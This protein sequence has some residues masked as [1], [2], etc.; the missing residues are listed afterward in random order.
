MEELPAECGR[1]RADG[2]RVSFGEKGIIVYS[3]IS[4]LTFMKIC[5]TGKGFM[6]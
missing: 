5:S 1:L 2:R 4:F 3:P 6:R